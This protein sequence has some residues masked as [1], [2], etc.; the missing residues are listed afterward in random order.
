MT[1]HIHALVQYPGHPDACF[2]LP[3]EDHMLPVLHASKTALRP[4]VCPANP[5]SLGKAPADGMNAV[6]VP[7]GLSFSPGGQRV[8]GDIVEI[9]LR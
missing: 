5:W 1:V 3:I 8:I 6:D 9:I 2:N 4:P 7:H